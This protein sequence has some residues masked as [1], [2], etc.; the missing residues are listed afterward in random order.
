MESEGSF[1]AG[2]IDSLTVQN[3][4]IAGIRGSW[5][6]TDAAA[7]ADALKDWFLAASRNNDTITSNADLKITD[8]FNYAARNFQPMEGSPVLNASIWSVSQVNVTV[9]GG[10]AA[11][12]TSD[13]GTIQLKAEVLPEFA[14]NKSVTWSIVAG[15][16]K[17]SIDQNGLLTSSGTNQGNGTV[18]VKATANDGSGASGTIAVTVSNQSGI[19]IPVTSVAVSSQSGTTI[20]SSS[21]TLQLIATVLPV[22]ASVNTVTWSSNNEAVATVSASGVVSGVSNGNATITATATDGSNVSGTL[23]ITIDMVSS[24]E[25]GKTNKLTAY[26]NPVS[27]FLTISGEVEIM[28]INI[29]NVNGQVIK[30]IDQVNS[31]ETVVDMSELSRGLY[32]LNISTEKGNSFHRITKK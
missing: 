23:D 22:D 27:D 29:I 2:A 20:T 21:Q 11:T 15:S 31:T 7:G 30:T 12:I 1:A 28:R 10:G 24:I 4:F 14:A 8:P 5:F 32:L 18:T 3:T 26:P 19:D 9:D 16:A 17:A 6:Q 25:T 13:G